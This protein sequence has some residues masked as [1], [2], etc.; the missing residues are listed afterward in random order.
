MTQEKGTYQPK[1]GCLKSSSIFKKNID[2]TIYLDST[3]ITAKIKSFVVK[4]IIEDRNASYDILST[5]AVSNM[6][7]K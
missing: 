1:R 5:D 4:R 3:T 6:V 2:K 7:L